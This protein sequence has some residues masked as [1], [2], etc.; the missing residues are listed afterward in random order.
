MHIL[1]LFKKMCHSK[2]LYIIVETISQYGQ[3]YI[4]ELSSVATVCIQTLVDY[5]Q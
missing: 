3:S 5:F 1:F 2:Y 4:P